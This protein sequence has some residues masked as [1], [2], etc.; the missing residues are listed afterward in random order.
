MKSLKKNQV[1]LERFIET[2]MHSFEQTGNDV[3]QLLECYEEEL[4]ELRTAYQ[5][6]C[7]TPLFNENPNPQPVPNDLARQLQIAKD[8]NRGLRM[9]LANR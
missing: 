3:E 1:A 2:S 9:D 4:E 7:V 6:F 8:G 5:P